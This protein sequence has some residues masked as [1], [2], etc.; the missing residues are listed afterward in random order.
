MGRFEYDPKNQ[1]SLIFWLQIARR[2]ETKA[3]FNE[4]KPGKYVNAALL[5]YDDNIEAIDI[6]WDSEIEDQ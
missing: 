3:Q 4:G 2:W 6:R 5:K 1:Y